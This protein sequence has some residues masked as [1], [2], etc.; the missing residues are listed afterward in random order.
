MH[1]VKMQGLGNDFVMLDGFAAPLPGEAGA[2]SRRICDRHFGTGADGL[3]T[4]EPS[5]RADARM[6]VYNA[7]G[8]EAE[9]CG[10]G[11]RCAARLLLDRGRVPGPALTVETG[12]GLLRCE[13][14]EGGFTCDMGAPVLAPER[15]PVARAENRFALS[16]AAGPLTF[17]CVSMGNPHAVTFDLFPETRLF[18]RLGPEI[19]RDAAFPARTN[20]E[21][22]RVGNGGIT[23]RVWERGDG[24]TLACGTGACAVLVA[25]VSLG[26][27]PRENEV[28]LPGG[29][30][31]IRW[32]EDGHVYMT[33][34]AETVFEGDWPD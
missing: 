17:F 24:A 3:I 31:R 30:L 27:S 14:D 4:L 12:A 15:I 25:A 33:G 34:P 28:H 23:V 18:Q 11:L 9:M 6:R 26:L 5:G 19:E 32:A 29:A 16:T 7:D 1:F 8:S 10:N 20:V 13:R 22:C 21:F 2:L